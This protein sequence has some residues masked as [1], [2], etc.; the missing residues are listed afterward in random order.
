[1]ANATARPRRSAV[2]DVLG[3]LA[4]VGLA[5]GTGALSSLAGDEPS[6]YQQLAR[7]AW[8]P[9]PWVFGPVWTVLYVLMGS[10][11]FLVWRDGR[12]AARGWA[13]AIFAVQLALNAAWTPVFFGWRELGLALVVLALNWLAVLAMLVAF[14][15]VRRLAGWLVA[16]LLVWV[17]F[18]GALNAAIWY[19]S[20]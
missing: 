2:R 18:A 14:S 20:L 9:P 3:W 13:L 6:F 10:A 15:H 7:P 8:A 12:G 1:M 19:L 4:C 16:P 11:V 17:S 5:L